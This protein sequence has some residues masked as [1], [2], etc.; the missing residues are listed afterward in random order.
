MLE[1]FK[2][3]DIGF[4][5]DG[6][7]DRCVVIDD[8]G[9]YVDD[10]V[11][12]ALYAAYKADKGPIVTHIGASIIVNKLVEEAGGK[13]IRVRVGDP[14]LA[15]AAF[16]NHA[17]F[18]GEPNGARIHPDVHY[19]PDGPL[20][21]LR[22]L[23]MIEELGRPLSE[24]VDE[25]PKTVVLREA[26]KRRRSYEDAMEC[27]KSSAPEDAL[28]ISTVDGI[29]VRTGEMERYL[30]RPSAT[31]PLIRIRAEAK[32][33]RRAKELIKTARRI[34]EGCV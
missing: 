26:V 25:V 10:H 21:L 34:A 12:L 15:R 1:L 17:A 13:V 2:G 28:E 14:S 20:T 11:M 9:R 4:A 29:R 23:Q 8:R 22:I 24:L 3:F 31:E 5:F 16:E 33:E 6:D 32:D 18:A 27:V 30:V 7:A 19:F